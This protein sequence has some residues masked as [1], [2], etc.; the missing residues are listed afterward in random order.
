MEFDALLQRVAAYYKL[1]IPPALGYSPSDLTD[2]LV[3]RLAHLYQAEFVAAF[4]GAKGELEPRQLRL[5]GLSLNPSDGSMRISFGLTASLFLDFLL[6]WCYSLLSLMLAVR[7]RTGRR[8]A[9][10]VYG[11]GADDII[12]G[13][14]DAEF[15]AYCDSGPIAPL[16]DSSVLIVQLSARTERSP[17]AKAFYARS[18]LHALCLFAGL[19]P[20]DALRLA[21]LHIAAFARLVRLAVAVPSLLLL[22]R[23]FAEDAT[24]SVLNGAGLLEAVVLTNSNYSSQP[25]WM[26][27][28]P[29]RKFR[30]HMVWYSQN[31]RPLLRK[32][33]PELTAYP[34]HRL[35]RADVMWVWTRAFADYLGRIG[36]RA[37]MQN[38]GPVLWRLPVQFPQEPRVDPLIAVFDVT[39]VTEAEAFRLGEL[40]NYYSLATAQKFL[41]DIA[42]ATES[43]A[44]QTGRRARIALKHKRGKVVNRDQKYFRFIEELI[45]KHGNLVVVPAQNSLYQMIENCDLVVAIP[46]SSPAYVASHLGKPCLFYDPT[47]TL[48]PTLEPA[49][50]LEFASGPAALALAL[51]N[52]V[53]LA[54]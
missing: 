48:R 38:V 43:T 2:R 25:L 32:S 51:K 45:A 16:R 36:I 12:R 9:T 37:D 18:P 17:G 11:V 49:P 39:P 4:C 20:A 14:N 40:D 8:R 28:K 50:L 54:R 22:A 44:T 46:Y 23:D 35:I 5:R 26:R 27:P 6:R 52:L 42:E 29:G 3:Q 1:R 31:I 21:C 13:G 33:D 7:T 41:Q 30:V 34:A 47:G 15:L 19:G 10:L 24:A 53:K